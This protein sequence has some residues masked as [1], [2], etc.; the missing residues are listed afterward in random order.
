MSD[1]LYDDDISLH[2]LDPPLHDH[3]NEPDSDLDDIDTRVLAPLGIDDFN[4]DPDAQPP[5]HSRRDIIPI[6]DV[7]RH[8]PSHVIWNN[9]YSV[10][11]RGR[12]FSNVKSNAIIEHIVAC[13]N[14]P[15]ISLLY[16]EGQLFPRI[17][18]CAKD[19]SVLGAIPSFLM[20]TASNRPFGLAPLLEHHHVRLRDGDILTSRE[21]NYW[22][23]L[24]DVKLTTALNRV[25]SKLVFK[26]G[27]EILEDGTKLVSPEQTH[28]PMDEAE[29]TRRIKELT[30]L[31]KK[32]KWTY[33]LT[34]TVNDHETPGVR[35][36]TRAIER[37]AAGDMQ[38]EKKLT[39]NFC[40]L[41]YVLGRDL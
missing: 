13:T 8:V 38:L 36:I 27:L 9:Q 5:M 4:V 19:G 3:E 35:E 22:H 6:Y 30:S 21:A 26:R 34:V 20:N 33:F 23:Y 28:L 37:V 40:H 2:V 7:K 10:L 1:D 14:S 41:S 12:R 11:R 16:P 31:L 29:A 24:F 25:P 32:G 18:W 39:D 15:S 17:F